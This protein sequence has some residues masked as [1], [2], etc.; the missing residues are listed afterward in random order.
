[1]TCEY[2][3]P[4]TS[5]PAI[6]FL[7][8]PI[9]RA[10][11][12]LADG[13]GADTGGVA[14]LPVRQSLRAKRD[15]Q[16]VSRREPSNRVEDDVRAIEAIRCLG[17][18]TGVAFVE[19]GNPAMQPPLPVATDVRRDGIQPATGIGQRSVCTKLLDEPREGV[20]HDILRRLRLAQHRKRQPI[21]S[22]GVQIEQ[23]RDCR[24]LGLDS[25]FF[26]RSG[27][28]IRRHQP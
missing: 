9:E 1:V 28:G 10:R 20:L 24:D 11:Q 19:P 17:C 15:E 3:Q 23:R 8:Q 7:L 27:R 14:D 26:D 21:H 18:A 5:A 13:R 2:L 25:D 16:T 6:Q 4:E 22:V 12:K